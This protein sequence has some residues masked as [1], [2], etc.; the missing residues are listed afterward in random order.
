MASDYR[1]YVDAPPKFR[2]EINLT[3][4]VRTVAAEAEVRRITVDDVEALS[5]L[6]L[7]AYVGTID[8]EDE[9]LRDALQEVDA[10]FEGEPMLE[11]SFLAG[12]DGDVASA[13]LVLQWR[14]RP[15]IGYVMTTPRTRTRVLAARWLAPRCKASVESATP[16]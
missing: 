7:D 2:Y 4:P 9:T 12:I 5:Q 10:Y 15:F 6:M 11:H 13:V 1:R 16:G 14:Q 8:Y 3:R